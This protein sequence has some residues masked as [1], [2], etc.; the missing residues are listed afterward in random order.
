MSNTHIEGRIVRIARPDTVLYSLFENLTNFTQNMPADMLS[1]AH[2]KATPNTL[3]AKVKGFEIGM[4]V[5]ERTPFTQ[6]KY[7]QYG[8][9]PIPF[10][11]TVKLESMGPNTTD[12]Q[13][14]MDTELSGI[15]KMMLGGKL[16][17]VVDKITDQLETTLG[18]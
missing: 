18:A 3:I 12:F 2:I 8:A 5:T 17:E 13:L 16:Q 4:H 10:M 15:Y 7:E 11:F 6:I 14:I 9:T 1:Q